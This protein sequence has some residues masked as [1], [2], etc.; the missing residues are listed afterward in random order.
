MIVMRTRHFLLAGSLVVALLSFLAVSLFWLP[1]RTI[2]LSMGVAN[3]VRQTDDLLAHITLTNR[4]NV[5]IAVPLRYRCQAESEGGS[6]NYT[7]DTRYTIFLQ[8]EQMVVLSRSNYAVPLPPDTTA[9]TLKLQ[10]RPQ[11]RREALLHALYHWKVVKQW[12]DLSKWSRLFGPP[13]KDEAFQ[14]TDCQSGSFEVPLGPA[15]PGKE[16]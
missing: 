14:W 5:S 4:G 9:W 16:P 7:A 10:V 6:T 8:P 11:T 2:A 12:K 3:Y 15:Q 13:E 1:A